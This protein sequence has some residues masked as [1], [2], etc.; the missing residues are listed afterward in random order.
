MLAA[1]DLL[2]ETEADAAARQPRQ[3]LIGGLLRRE[4]VAAACGI[5]RDHLE[6]LRGKADFVEGKAASGQ[7]AP[8]WELARQLAGRKAARGPRP[9]AVQKA[10]DG[11]IISRREDLLECW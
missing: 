4:S 11:L 6:R 7:H 10:A 8:L 9:I 2:V 5:R 3:A 1:A